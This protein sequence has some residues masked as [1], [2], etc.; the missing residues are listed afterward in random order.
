MLVDLT[1]LSTQQCM[2]KRS[3]AQI[4]C[5][6]GNKTY[7][8][9]ASPDRINKTIS[10]TRLPASTRRCTLPAGS[11]TQRHER[12]LP[13]R[14]TLRRRTTS[15][16]TAPERIWKT[17]PCPIEILQIVSKASDSL[18]VGLTLQK[19]EK[20]RVKVSVLITT[21]VS[22]PHV[23]IIR[24]IFKARPHSKAMSSK[25]EFSLSSFSSSIWLFV[26]LTHA[27]IVSNQV[28]PL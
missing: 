26:R 4:L 20:G 12:L 16:E 9:Y 19:I 25:R 27:N 8:V 1:A 14:H 15:P 10:C 22:I 18:S 21:I 7:R 3:L 11:P 23:K 24:P 28:N 13:L 5:Y 2:L 17:S 6:M